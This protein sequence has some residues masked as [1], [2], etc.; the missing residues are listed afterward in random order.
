MKFDSDYVAI[1]FL[2]ARDYKFL[3]NGLIR[4]PA[5]HAVTFEERKALNYLCGEWDYAL[6][7][8]E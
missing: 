7:D 5:G 1:S 8:E 6:E 2:K 3:T 4:K